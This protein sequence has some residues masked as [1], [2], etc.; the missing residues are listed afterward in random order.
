MSWYKNISFWSTVLATCALVLSQL[1]PISQWFP[2]PKLEIIHADRIGI[3][4]SFGLLVFNLPLELDN[5]GNIPLDVTRI[6]FEVIGPNGV[7]KTYLAEAFYEQPTN[8]APPINLP[9][10]SI[11]LN[12]E[13]LWGE[14]VYFSQD[15]DPSTEEELNNIRLSIAKSIHADLDEK[16]SAG[17]LSRGEA[18]PDVTKIAEE[19]FNNHFD[20]KKGKYKTK[21]IIETAQVDLPFIIESEFTIYDYHIETVKAQTKA[22]A[23]DYRYGAG[24][25]FPSDNSKQTW[26]KLQPNQVAEGF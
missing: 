7:K 25:I 10:A 2:R 5:K 23:D 19:Y 1:P 6:T 26:I 20:L 18:E 11:N 24:I 9:I 4:S 17:N 13:E 21:L 15:I 22:Q 14:L 16:R 3:N 8:G 12:E